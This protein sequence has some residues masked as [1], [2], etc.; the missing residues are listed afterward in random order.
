MSVILPQPIGADEG[1]AHTG[2]GIDADILQQF[3]V[4]H[5]AKVHMLKRNL[6]LQAKRAQW[7]PTA[8]GSCSRASSNANMRRAEAYA[9]GFA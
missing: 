6:A 5:I 2:L 3:A 4:G 7:H 8:S 9:S 1:I